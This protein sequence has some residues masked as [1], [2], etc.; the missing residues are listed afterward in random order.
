[1]KYALDTY[2]KQK[3]RQLKWKAYMV[4]Q[5]ATIAAIEARRPRTKAEL[6]AIPG[7]GPAKVARFGD[8]ILALVARNEHRTCRRS[9]ARR[10]LSGDRT[11]LAP[12]A[13]R[14]S[15]R[16]LCD[17]ARSAVLVRIRAA[18]YSGSHSERRMRV[19]SL[20]RVDQASTAV[21]RLN[22]ETRSFHDAADEGWLALLARDVTRSDYQRQLVTVYGFEGPLEAAFAYTPNLKLFVDLRQRSRAGLIAKDLLAL[23]LRANAIAT[24][25]QCLLA[26][27]SGPVEALGW[28]YV[29]ERAT[30]L[31]ERAR[32]HLVAR[33]PTARYL[34]V[35]RRVSGRGRRA[36]ERARSCTRS[37]G[38]LGSAHG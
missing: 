33:S 37:R 19:A 21:M 22:L 11:P 9:A 31:H 18:K 20:T 2:R 34:R 17:P 30:L 1:M 27:F 3:A 36:L 8:D 14:L 10:R 6:L 24:I 28:M 15:A 35:H 29:A 12:G 38:S 26:P 13:S 32:R 5:R 23:G 25:P 16:A 7:L 4:L